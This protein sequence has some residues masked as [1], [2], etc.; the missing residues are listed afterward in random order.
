MKETKSGVKEDR[1]VWEL[2]KARVVVR[3][4]H[5][6]VESDPTTIFCPL[7]Y[8]FS[9][10]EVNTRETLKESME[11]FMK[12]WGLC[13][14]NRT[15]ETEAM[16]VGYGASETNMTAMQNGL[17]DAVVIPCDGAGTVISDKPTVVEGIGMLSGGLLETSPIP[18]V[19]DGL[20]AKGAVVVFPETAEINQVE[21]LRRAFELGYGRVGVTILGPEA[22][23]VEDV[24]KLEREYGKTA[25]I[26][27]VHSTGMGKELA[28][29]VEKCD[30]AHGCASKLIREVMAPKA[31]ISFGKNVP[32][33]AFTDRGKEMLELQDKVNKKNKPILKLAFVRPPEPA[34]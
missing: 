17:L 3:K 19:I 26:T 14:P 10:V 6:S 30:I 34:Q 21:G 7:R 32:V 8:A 1:H 28:P 9:G 13:M 4:G 22:Q 23:L 31:K 15:L 20:V 24:R 12:M 25:V 2:A 29:Y 16:A 18:E 33:Y 5:V 11:N 27:L